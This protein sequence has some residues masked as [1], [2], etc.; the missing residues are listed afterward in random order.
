M[1]SNFNVG[2]QVILG[3]HDAVAPSI[4]HPHGPINWD[5]RMDQYVGKVATLKRL[6]T[7][8][9]IWGYCWEID[10][11]GGVF[12]WHEKNMIAVQMI[13][14]SKLTGSTTM[15]K[16][17]TPKVEGA[18]CSKCREFNNYAEPNMPDGTFKCYS[19]RH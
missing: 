18:S 8:D 9:P 10:L 14:L 13:Q 17:A 15:V 7:L 2:D 3:R 5:P 11:D 16:R 12:A 4:Q 6:F 19:C 1:S